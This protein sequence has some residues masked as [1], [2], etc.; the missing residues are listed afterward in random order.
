MNDYVIGPVAQSV[1][2]TQKISLGG[3]RLS[4]RSVE[5]PA[6]AVLMGNLGSAVNMATDFRMLSCQ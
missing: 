5:L 6:S 3:N 2:S 1:N 4:T